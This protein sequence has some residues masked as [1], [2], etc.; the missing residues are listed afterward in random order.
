M[1][2][3]GSNS[4][5]RH[6]A[7][8]GVEMSVMIDATDQRAGRGQEAQGVFLPP[9]MPDH[10]VRLLKPDGILEVSRRHLSAAVVASLIWGSSPSP[11]GII[12]RWSKIDECRCETCASMEVQR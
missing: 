10:R 8:R 1:G 3:Q 11:T 7:S 4:I 5:K 2:R 9:W 12:A 6:H